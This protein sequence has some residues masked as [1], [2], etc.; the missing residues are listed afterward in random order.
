MSEPLETLAPSLL[1]SATYDNQSQSA[2]LKF[3]NPET[4]KVVLWKDQTGHKPYCYSKLKPDE[5]GFLSSRKDIIKIEAVKRK[6]FLKDE[7]ET[8]SKIIVTDPLAIGGTQTDKSIRNIIETWESDIKYYE[9]YLYD[10]GLIVG[11]FYRIEN[12]KIIPHDFELSEDVNL[13]M[14]S[15]L[16]DANTTKGLVDVKEFQE[17]ITQWAHLLNQ[18]IPKI[19]RLSF[20]IEVESEIGRIPD[21]KIAEKRITAVGFAGSDGF[22]QV[23]VL[24]KTGSTDG[25]SELPPDVK[26]TFYAENDEKKM[27]EDAF[28][29]I[30]DYPF[31]ITYNGDDFD[32]PY[33]YNRAERLGLK[34]SD[35]PLY[36][37]RDSA[38]LKHG[39]HI[40]L[41]RTMSNRS[42]QIYAFSHKYTDFSLNSVTKA[43]LGES[44][45]DYGVDLDRLTNYQLA[46][47]CYNDARITLKLTSFNSDL[48]MNLLVVISRIAR[49]P[50]DD[51]ARMGVSQWIR[52]LLYYEHRQR[53]AMIPRREELDS[54]SQGVISDAI[55][56]DKKYRGGLVI[57]PVEGIHF[58]V[59]VMDFACFDTRTEVLTTKGWKTHLSLQ[60]ND[61]ALTVNLRTGNIEKNKIKKIF[62]YDYNGK[63]Y[64]IK[65]PKKLDFLFT[66]NHRVVYKIKTGGNTW[67]WNDKL[68]V[69]EINK[70]GNYHISL[71]YFGNWKGKKTTHIKIGQSTFKINYWLEFF[72]RFLGDGYLT[73]RSIRIYENSKNVKKIKRLSYLIKKLG[74]TPKIKYEEKKN[75]VVISINDKKLS[76][77][78]KNH[79]SGKTHSKDRCVPENYHEYSKEHLEFLLRGMID[80]DGSISKSGEITYSTVNKNLANDFQL[81]ALKV[82]YNC[83]ITK[84]V[85][86]RFGRKTN[87]Y[88]CVLS[89]F[90]KKNASFVV[91]KQYKHIREQYYKGSVW[92]ANTHNTTLIIRRRGRVIVTG[93]SLYPSII[94][95]R[96][97]SYET[98]RC[99]HKE[100]KANTIPDTN[101]WVCTKHN[102][103]TSM[104]IGSLRDLRVNYYKHLAKKAKTQ[105]E[106]ERYTVVSQA[107]KVIL[108]ASYGVMGAEIF[109]LYFLPAA[110]ATTAVGRH[111]IME[112]IKKCQESNVQVLYS[113]TDSLFIKNPTPE[114]IAAIIESAKNTHGVDLEVDKE[115]RYVVLSNRK[116]N[117]LGVTKDGKVDVKGLTGKKSHTP[118]FIRNLFYELLDI[119]S[120]VETANDFEAAKKKI[121]DKIS[122][123][124]TKVKE[125][126]IPIPDLAFNVMISKAPD[127]YDKTVPQHIRA[128]KLLEQHREIKRGDIISYVKI[129][130]KPGVKP[131][132]MARQDEIDSAKYMEFM[133][134]TLDQI[135]SSM[136]LDFDKIVG[137][138][139]QTGLDQF[140][141]S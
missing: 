119:L 25:T 106:K 138:P 36:M 9:N 113:D 44:K 47:Y 40:D 90:R 16:L 55:I 20:D 43:L 28:K 110:E 107:L 35:N 128:A 59:I 131:V 112:T 61:V 115:Y 26:V 92:C 97:L 136:D 37:M 80:S 141:W 52:S 79:L 54:K 17:Y 60:K 38:T 13:A 129:I 19:R 34:N 50:V 21:P 104:L 6:N 39:V 76:G 101:H 23:F 32:M 109:P 4:Q 53:N 72:G 75:S 123:C 5:L 94:K 120:K 99:S 105:E 93:N 82:G 66:P 1:V 137:R 117:Y 71:P 121:S 58:Q 11:K 96:N 118:P 15:L 86:T 88:H 48:L 140:F 18:P 84:R 100:C 78:I 132:E 33:L 124:A 45:I 7:E 65:T 73:D 95:V 74:F 30:S 46:N 49:M 3:Y 42:F 2:V 103:L 22:K 133:E 114:Q 77:L 69:N 68:H 125:K 8:V 14:K 122:E 64:R 51:I 29:I 89:G 116:K 102:G 57:D 62:K 135:T 98:I 127:E 12:G 67:K 130:N 126:K 87:Y 10:Q 85:S 111:I 70:I 41:Y 139:K 81:L 108:N 31:V 91:S 63:I 134:S 56:K 27:I 24:R 83:S